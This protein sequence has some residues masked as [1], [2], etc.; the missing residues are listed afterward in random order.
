MTN[1][2]LSVVAALVQLESGGNFMAVGDGGHAI[3]ILQ[4]HRI[5]VDEA[6]RIDSI[7]AARERRAP[8]LWTYRDRLN[9]NKSRDMAFITLRFHYERGTTN[10]VALGGK[11]N[12]PYGPANDAYNRKVRREL[13][14]TGGLHEIQSILR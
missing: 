13:N 14:R 8:R 7:Y 11:W 5:A 4:L 12:R 6:V 1:L 9:P 2:I 3:G 10:A